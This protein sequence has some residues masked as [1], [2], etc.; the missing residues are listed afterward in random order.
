M[1]KRVLSESAIGA[2][3]SYAHV[4]PSSKSPVSLKVIQLDGMEPGV[5]YHG[6]R[7]LRGCVLAAVVE[8]KS[9]VDEEPRSVVRSDGGGI[10]AGSVDLEKA[11]PRDAE[12]IW[13]PTRRVRRQAT[14]REQRVDAD[15]D[16]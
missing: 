11:L 7:P 6:R 8:D 16:R 1:G 5:E 15:A 2:S 10:R 3:R 4:T 13:S 14:R 12:G 9:L